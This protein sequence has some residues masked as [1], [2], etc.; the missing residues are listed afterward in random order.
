MPKSESHFFR[1]SPRFFDGDASSLATAGNMEDAWRRTLTGNV[2]DALNRMQG[3][4]A[5]A[6]HNHEGRTI[7]AVDRFAVQSL[8]YRVR[9][10]RLAFAGRADDLADKR[11][12]VDP[13]SIFDYL[14]FHVIPSPRTIYK[15]IY[16]LP[17]GH[18]ALFENGRLSVA[19]Y[20]LPNFDERHDKSF[21]SLKEEFRQLPQ[22][23]HR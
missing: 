22:W 14:Y 9:D 18:Y 23:W 16:R 10:G 17:P 20:W 2:E 4:F 1:G 3:A 12:D 11:T 7:L 8:C 5:V 13:Q 21:G 15:G 19:P 6:L